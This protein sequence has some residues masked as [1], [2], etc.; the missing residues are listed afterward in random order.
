MSP[1]KELLDRL[2]A[3]APEE[4]K[5][6]RECQVTF[7]GS[8]PDVAAGAL[9]KDAIEGVYVLTV[10]GQQPTPSGRPKMLR[11]DMYFTPDKIRRVE[12]IGE[13]LSNLSIPDRKIV[14]PGVR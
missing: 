4:N 9:R 1:M 11:A 3:E 5:G 13:E 12:I 14:L 7:E 10:I 2:I 8:P 6:A